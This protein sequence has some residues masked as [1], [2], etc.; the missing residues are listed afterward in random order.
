MKTKT[1]LFL[2]ASGLLISF[3]FD[4]LKSPTISLKGTW[5]LISATT[6]T[7]GKSVTEDYRKN[8]RMIKI[9]NDT[10]FAFL[11]HS[12]R[13]KKDS[14]NHFDA[15]GGTYT[16]KGNQYTEHLEYYADKNWEGKTFH[17]TVGL[18]NDTLIQKGV[19][20]VEKENINRLIIEKYV[21]LK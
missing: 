12:L 5:Q 4:K 2:L 17:F 6:I 11:K 1:L 19:E 8:E 14:S 7:K 13:T 21:R 3:S 20:K 15:G 16:L 18:K 10:H 9:I